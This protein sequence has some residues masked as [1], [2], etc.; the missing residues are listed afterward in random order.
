VRYVVA[1]SEEEAKRRRTVFTADGSDNPSPAARAAA[2]RQVKRLAGLSADEDAGS[3]G[4][5]GE[6]DAAFPA[7]L[8]SAGDAG[9]AGAGKLSTGRAD[10]MAAALAFKTA[11]LFGGRHARTGDTSGRAVGRVTRGSGTVLGRGSGM[12]LDSSTRGAA[13]NAAARRGQR[14]GGGGVAAGGGGGR[15][16]SR[17]LKRGRGMASAD[18]FVVR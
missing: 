12:L 4:E 13:A 7:S 14:Q 3:D 8:M 9:K 11:M 6:G 18:G 1:P 17:V 5:A 10:T 15:A 16:A 2:L